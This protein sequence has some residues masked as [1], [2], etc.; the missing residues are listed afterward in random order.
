LEDAYDIALDA[1]AAEA[2]EGKY[3]SSKLGEMVDREAII[4]RAIARLS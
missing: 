1:A 4:D 3:E 2:F